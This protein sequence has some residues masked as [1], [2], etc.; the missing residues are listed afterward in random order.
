MKVPFKHFSFQSIVKLEQSITR[1]II[2]T[3]FSMISILDKCE[4]FFRNIRPYP[5]TRFF[6]FQSN[7]KHLP[8]KISRHEEF[9]FSN[10]SYH[11]FAAASVIVL[12]SFSSCTNDPLDVDV[13]GISVPPVKILRYEKDFFALDT[14]K[15]AESLDR[16]HQ[17]FGDF[18]DGFVNHIVCSQAPD[19]LGCDYAI[20]DFVLNAGYRDVLKECNTL[21]PTDFSE[22]ENGIT[23]A[24]KHFRYHFP[25]RELPKNVY[26]TMTGFNY[27][28]LQISNC[29]GIGLEYYLGENNFIYYSESLRDKWPAYRRHV[30]T[31]EYMLENFVK[32]WMMNEFPYDPPKNDLINKMVYEGKLL[33]LEKAL[34]RNTPDSIIMGF[35]QAKLDWCM[36]NEAKMWATLIEQKKVYS[37][38]E[39]D[40]NHFTADGPFSPG[41]PKESPGKA[42]TWIGL[43]IVEAFME[44]NPNVSLEELMKLKDGAALLNRSKYKPKF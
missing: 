3:I 33:Y 14:N 19:S 6:S 29:Y 26:T 36:E 11:F 21:F 9:F 37:D 27:G 4:R 32:A 16:L 40:I 15:M 10:S 8:S 41:F 28:I 12:I 43:K 5:K 30:S 20:R 44:K 35:P 31:K 42:G 25:K 38:N 24:Y 1:C 23:D 18:N 22:L 17:R 7:I 2:K 13:S 39:D 34:L